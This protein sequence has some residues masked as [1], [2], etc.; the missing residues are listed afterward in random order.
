MLEYSYECSYVILTKF[1]I[2][3]TEFFFVNLVFKL[4]GS[5]FKDLE[6]DSFWFF[7]KEDIAEAK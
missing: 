6:D 7:F 2:F 4:N 3:I 1:C 5:S